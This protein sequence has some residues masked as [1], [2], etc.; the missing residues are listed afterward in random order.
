MRDNRKISCYAYSEW[1][2]LQNKCIQL[3][4][5]SY[6]GILNQIIEHFGYTAPHDRKLRSYG[7]KVIQQNVFNTFPIV[8]PLNLL[9]F[10]QCICWQ[11]T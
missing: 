8:F 9:R 10:M 1:C 4:T 6:Y 5:M 3:V 2:W 11:I 7:T